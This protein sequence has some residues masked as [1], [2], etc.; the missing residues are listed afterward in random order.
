M[1]NAA[2][3]SA[4]Q[5]QRLSTFCAGL[6]TE[7]GSNQRLY[8]LVHEPDQFAGSCQQ[9][10]SEFHAMTD[11]VRSN[12]LADLPEPTIIASHML[13]FR[14]SAVQVPTQYADTKCYRNA[15]TAASRMFGTQAAMTSAALA[16]N[17]QMAGALQQLADGQVDGILSSDAVRRTN[18]LSG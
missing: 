12:V 4:T 17:P 3:L 13:A 16:S 6:A 9:P 5:C 14:P 8:Q 11:F 15:L 2:S 7:E 1:W 18:I 10:S